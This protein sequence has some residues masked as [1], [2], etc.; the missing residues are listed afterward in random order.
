MMPKNNFSGYELAFT[1]QAAKEFKKLDRSDAAKIDKKLQ[2]LVS[3]TQNLD[4]K[5][6]STDGDAKYRLRCGD[7]RIIFE[8]KHSIITILVIGIG[9][10]KEVYREY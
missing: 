9:H 10:R 2:E 7:Y 4:I 5:K 1:T 3:G 6:M 8:V